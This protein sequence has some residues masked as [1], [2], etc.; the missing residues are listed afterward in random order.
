MLARRE[1]FHHS[2]NS[3]ADVNISQVLNVFD[4]KSIIHDV[5]R[6]IEEVSGQRKIFECTHTSPDSP[7]QSLRIV[8]SRKAKQVARI[9]A[10]VDQHTHLVQKCSCFFE[11]N[12]VELTSKGDL[13][14][15]LFLSLCPSM[16]IVRSIMYMIE[17]CKYGM[18]PEKVD[19]QLRVETKTN[20][21]Q[22]N[23]FIYGKDNA[24]V[25]LQLSS[26]LSHFVCFSKENKR[27]ISFPPFLSIENIPH[28]WYLEKA[29]ANH[30]NDNKNAVPCPQTLQAMETIFNLIGVDYATKTHTQYSSRLSK[31]ASDNQAEARTHA[32]E[33]TPNK[34]LLGG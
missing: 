31:K 6:L 4:V 24:F 30:N 7:I 18:D 26:D 32:K 16:C 33:G 14:D 22:T 12:V 34:V 9:T 11:K 28:T 5:I 19:S 3:K 21:T 13:M 27:G 15:Y 17:T 29:F 1:Y 2:M 10:R 25:E 20:S 8:D 23:I